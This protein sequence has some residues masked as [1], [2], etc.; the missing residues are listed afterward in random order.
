M[1]FCKNCGQQLNDGA[2]FCA[3]CGTSQ[4]AQ[5]PQANNNQAQQQAPIQ[6]QVMTGDADVQATKSVA[7]LSYL[8]ILFLIPMFAKKTSDYCRFHVNQ[9]ATFFALELAYTIVTEILK[10]ICRAVFPGQWKYALFTAYYYDQHIIT[11]IVSIIFALG[12]IALCVLAIIGIVNA[13][14]GKK[15]E[16][17]LIG[18]IPVIGDLLDKIYYNK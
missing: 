13:A 5:Q 18:Q 8:G 12:S 14:T 3:N 10:A 9:G 15:K 1:A 2:E 16:L 6:P 17:P 11:K 7:W 4:S